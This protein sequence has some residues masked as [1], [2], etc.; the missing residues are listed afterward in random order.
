MSRPL[1]GLTAGE[2]KDKTRFDSIV[3]HGQSYTYVNAAVSAGGAPFVI[4]LTTDLDALRKVYDIL[5][6]VMLCGGNDLNPKLYGQDPYETTVEISDLRDEVEKQLLLWA[7]EDK[8][9]VLGICRG[10]QLV[11]V[12]HGGTLH[13]H[14]PTDIPDASNHTLSTDLADNHNIA[15]KLK[16]DPESRL[17][18]ILESETIGVNT[19][20]HQAIN[21]LG[22]GLKA[23]AYSEDGLIE[24]LESTDPKTYLICVQSH[25]E[26]LASNKEIGWQKLFRSFTEAAQQSSSAV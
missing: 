13:Q 18:K 25:P 22:G 4:P 12:I 26:S 1:I 7:L 3:V 17:A 11:N 6:G 20:H 8:K 10:M 21:K 16:I 14:I 19:H 2:V 5:H 24:A 15:H 23:T 9:P